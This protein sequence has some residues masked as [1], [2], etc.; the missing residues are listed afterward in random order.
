MKRILLR[1]WITALTF[2]LGISVSAAWHIYKLSNLP[3]S[4]RAIVCQLLVPQTPTIVDAHFECHQKT[5]YHSYKLS[6]G[7]WVC[8][9]CEVFSTRQAASFALA[10]QSREL[11]ISERS[12]THDTNGRPTGET[13]TVTTPT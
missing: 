10:K 12:I 1:L 3:D 11:E 13:I 2:G 9:R 5:H 6:D 8:N 4:P 7:T